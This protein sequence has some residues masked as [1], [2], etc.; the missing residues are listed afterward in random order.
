[1][2]KFNEGDLVHDREHGRGIGIVTE[3]DIDG[4]LRVEF[5]FDDEDSATDAPEWRNADK[6][7][8][9]TRSELEEHIRS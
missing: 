5:L 3:T 2:R 1:M 7:R 8:R 6:V 4:G 9:P